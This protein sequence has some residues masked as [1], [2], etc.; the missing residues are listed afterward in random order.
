MDRSN[1]HII[2]FNKY[3]CF[4]FFL[5]WIFFVFVLLQMFDSNQNKDKLLRLK[6]GAGKVIRVSESILQ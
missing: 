6:I 2:H 5:L 4:L 1:T 3:Q